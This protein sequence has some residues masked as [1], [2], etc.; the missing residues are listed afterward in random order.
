MSDESMELIERSSTIGLKA[1]TIRDLLQ[2]KDG[3]DT[4]FKTKAISNI[5]HKFEVLVNN[6]LGI[7]HDTSTAK[8]AILYLSR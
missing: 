1:S 6:K 2:V 8:K 4:R 7:S 5:L 3:S